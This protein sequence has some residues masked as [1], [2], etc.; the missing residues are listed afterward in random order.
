MGNYSD[1]IKDRLDKYLQYQEESISNIGIEYTEYLMENLDRN[2]KYTE[3]L[4]GLHI[5]KDIWYVREKRRASIKKIFCIDVT[6]SF[7]ESNI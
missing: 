7:L 6:V 5:N 4:S 1:Y 2:I 3:Y